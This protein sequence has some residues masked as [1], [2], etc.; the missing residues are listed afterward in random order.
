MTSNSSSST[1]EKLKIAIIG[2]GPSG[3]AASYTLL[4]NYNCQVDMIDVGLE[5]D[6]ETFTFKKNAKNTSPD[7]FL[8]KIEKKRARLDKKNKSSIP[9]KLLFGS[10]FVY[11]KIDHVKA[12]ID[13]TVK[14]NFTFAKGGL[15]K[16]WGANVSSILQ[17]DINTWPISEEVLKPYFEQIE[18]IVPISSEKDKL[19][20]RFK[21]Q[22]KGNY[23]FPLASS[24]QKIIDQSL[25]NEETLENAGIYVGR[26]KLAVSGKETNLFKKCISCGLCMHGCPYESIFD[27]SVIIEK[28]FKRNKSFRYLPNNLIIKIEENA[29]GKVILS[30]RNTKDNSLKNVTYDKVFVAC[31]SIASTALIARSFSDC[32]KKIIIK[33]SQKYLFPFIVSKPM[34][35]S[36]VNETTNTLAQLVLHIE[37]LKHTS[38][39]VHIQLYSFNDLMAKPVRKFLGKAI[40][41]FL[42]FILAPMLDKVM[43]GMMYLHSDSS[44]HLSL[45]VNPNNDVD[46]EIS[47]KNSNLSDMVFK[48]VKDKI[49]RYYKEI[50]GFIVARFAVKQ[51]PGESQHFGASMPMKKAPN[52]LETDIL[53]RPLNLKN[54]HIVDTS[55]LPNIPSTPTTLLVMANASRIVDQCLKGEIK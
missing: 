13:D 23:S 27:P 9:Q 20:K 49:N 41:N 55:I 15:G 25:R 12:K 48:E 39:V 30:K 32:S 47:G 40:T 2:S 51:L 3:V 38:K 35:K 26:A 1:K 44:G 11:Q 46:I 5:M 37:N 17:K 52:G 10:D 53:G 8:E 18:R 45:K 50:G 29:C 16:I 28:Y 43:I 34:K 24:S 14:L 21:Y 22:P 4:K 6:A 7:I 19:G 36:L 42:L 54:T 33:D 31:G